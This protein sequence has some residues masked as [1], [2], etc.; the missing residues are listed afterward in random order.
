MSSVG[1]AELLVIL[2]IAAIVI[3]P[4]NARSLIHIIGKVVRTFRK[5]MDELKK[6]VD[7][8]EEFEDI[9]QEIESA[10]SEMS[11]EEDINEIKNEVSELKKK[12]KTIEDFKKEKHK[13]GNIL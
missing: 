2:L 12:S 8:T 11:L 10:A 4:E 7:F 5:S 9:K 13:G 1:G 3:G 6:S